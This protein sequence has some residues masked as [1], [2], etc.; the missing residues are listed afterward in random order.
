MVLPFYHK[1]KCFTQLPRCL[2]KFLNL[3]ILKLVSGKR[4]NS[5][6]SLRIRLETLQ[7]AGLGRLTRAGETSC[8][9][10]SRARAQRATRRG[11]A[12]TAVS[13]A[14]VRLAHTVCGSGR[15]FAPD[16]IAMLTK[17]EVRATAETRPPTRRSSRRSDGLYL[18]RARSVFAS[19]DLAR[20]PDMTVRR[21]TAFFFHAPQTTLATDEDGD[22][23]RH[24]V[25]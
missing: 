7:A 6:V 2:S 11:R 3:K 16:R 22:G 10:G 5:S 15:R 9:V 14:G 25:R 17:F 12:A 24:A 13:T 8:R 1:C 18:A 20:R 23:D 21:V 19:N 4:I